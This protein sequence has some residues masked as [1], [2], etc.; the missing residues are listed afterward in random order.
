MHATCER[1]ALLRGSRE[2]VP[3]RL[4]FVSCYLQFPVGLSLALRRRL[5]AA[6]ALEYELY[7]ILMHT[8]GATGG[9]FFAYIKVLDDDDEV[10]VNL[11]P[12]ANQPARWLKFD[13]AV[14]S[15]LSADE[16][17]RIVHGNAAAAAPAVA[18]AAG[19]LSRSRSTRPARTR[20][21]ATRRPSP[22][23]SFWRP[24][25]N[26]ASLTRNCCCSR[27]GAWIWMSSPRI[28]PTT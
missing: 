6:N 25:P 14:I 12:S 20:A 2:H 17:E 16:I 27:R 3:V 28:A 21:P 26:A 10:G 13:D 22:P 5:V 19:T 11:A 7:T 8:G 18:V 4:C 1:V 23:P 15:E 9:H 24:R